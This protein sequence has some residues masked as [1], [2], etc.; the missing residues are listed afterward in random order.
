[1]RPSIQQR[2]GG[3]FDKSAGLLNTGG[4]AASLPNQL[5]HT[6]TAAGNVTLGCNDSGIA[7]V[8]VYS[9]KITALPLSGVAHYGS[10]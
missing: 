10:S 5:A 3:D 7:G 2:G 8:S 9:L 6:Q 4:S 1:M